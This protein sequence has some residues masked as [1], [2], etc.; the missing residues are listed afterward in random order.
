MFKMWRFFVVLALLLAVP[1][2]QAEASS[3]SGDVTY[4]TCAPRNIALGKII[5]IEGDQVVIGYAP[6]YSK[7]KLRR[8]VVAKAAYPRQLEFSQVGQWTCWKVTRIFTKPYPPARLQAIYPAHIYTK[9]A[10]VLN[11][12][13]K[14]FQRAFAAVQDE[15]MV[16]GR[17]LY[18]D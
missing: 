3:E 7:G 9:P 16:D 15:E 12:T 2:V 6:D 4:P 18:V 10:A 17:R 11:T 5:A 13:N 14:I 8:K 1:G